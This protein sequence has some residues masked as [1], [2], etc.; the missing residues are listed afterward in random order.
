MLRLEFPQLLHELVELGVADLR[1]VEHEVAVLVIGDLRAQLLDAQ[2]RALEVAGLDVGRGT[3]G[4]SIWRAG[5][6][7]SR[8]P[9]ARVGRIWRAAGDGRIGVR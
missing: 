2:F 7:D 4:S 6:S 8:V 9:T 1:L 5:T 3:H